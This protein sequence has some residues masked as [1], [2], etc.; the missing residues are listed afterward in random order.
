VDTRNNNDAMNRIS[1]AIEK[2]DLKDKV[3]LYDYTSDVFGVQKNAQIYALS[4]M[5][6][7]FNLSLMEALGN[8]MVGVTYDVNYG[9]NELVIDSENG[10]V[11]PF[12]SIEQLAEKFVELLLN[13]ELLQAMSTRAYELSERYSER[14]VWKAWRALLD[15]AAEKEFHYIEPITEGFAKY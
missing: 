14:N 3:K 13:D 9:P 15:D 12:N 10:Y 6:E 8:G 5:M 11:V 2:Y 7:G 1:A 4:S